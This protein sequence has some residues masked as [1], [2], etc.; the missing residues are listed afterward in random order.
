[1]TGRSGCLLD[2]AKQRQPVHPRH[3]D[4]GQ[5]CEQLRLDLLVEE[6][7]GFLA[8]VGEVHSVTLLHGSA[9]TG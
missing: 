7:E 8:R 4:V 1:M 9:S 5:D 3:V 6:L 2:L